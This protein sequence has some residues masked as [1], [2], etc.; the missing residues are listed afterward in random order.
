[1]IKKVLFVFSILFLTGCAQSISGTPMPKFDFSSQ[2]MIPVAVKNIVVNDVYQPPIAAPHVDHLFPLKLTEAVRHWSDRRFE[3]R[4]D[5]GTMYITIQEASVVEQP[6][7]RTTG[8][9]GWF[10]FD[11]AY[12]YQAKLVVEI[13]TDLPDDKRH[14]NHDSTRA[15]IEHSRTVGENAS[16]QE[17]EKAWVQLTEDVMQDLDLYLTKSLQEK[18]PFLIMN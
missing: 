6:L 9:K 11:Q 15:T 7:S 1:M 2:S 18:M 5:A 10:T 13:T 4:G 3:T 17:R 16:V 14:G 8:V 12:R